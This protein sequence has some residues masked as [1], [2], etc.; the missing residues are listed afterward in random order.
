MR[1]LLRPHRLKT[2]VLD[3]ATA[4]LRASSISILDA[5]STIPWQADEMEAQ[6]ILS[7]SLQLRFE[8]GRLWV[9]D[10]GHCQH[11][12]VNLEVCALEWRSFS[13]SWGVISDRHSWVCS[14]VWETWLSTFS[15]TRL[16]ANSI[17]MGSVAFREIAKFS[18]L[19]V[20]SW[21]VW[22]KVL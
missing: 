5:T 14:L 4:V 13:Y 18:S 3:I 11:S 8:N 16:Q 10:D 12:F 17:S 6:E 7:S 20:L 15:K 21:A 2:L 19:N 22:Q 1:S 9:V